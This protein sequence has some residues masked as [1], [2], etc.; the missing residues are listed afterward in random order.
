MTPT[1]ARRARPFPHPRCLAL[2]LLLLLAV[3]A[4]GPASAQDGPVGVLVVSA[5]VEGAEVWVDGEKVG[6]VPYTGY[7]PVG[8]HQVRVVA[9]DHDPFVRRVDLREAL[10]SSL[11]AKLEAGDGTV[12]FKVQPPASVV[13]IDGN[14]VGPAP[15]RIQDLAPGHHSYLVTA[16]GHES[17]AAEFDFAKGQNLFF[18]LELLSSAGLFE[19]D[20]TPP[21]AT[22]WLDGDQVGDTP[23]S[24]S[25][26][27]L[28]QHQVRVALDGYADV[29]RPV[30]TTDGRKGALD[31][32]LTDHGSRLTVKTGVDAASVLVNGSLAGQGARVVLPEVDRGT[33]QVAVSAPGLEP[34]E[35]SVRMPARGR[36]TVKADMLAAADGRSELVQLPPLYGRWTF[37]AASAAVAGGGV[38]GAVILAKA[39]EPPAPPQG[40]VLVVLP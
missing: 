14:P 2:T 28:G 35:L 22:V 38:A 29:F 34:A 26:V 37:W 30:D 19:V 23:L 7:L 32:T 18:E 25:G 3:L 20:T 10:T 40:D 5:S 12:E 24:I 16:D 4:A 31:L 36:V 27:A 13:H 1:A 9:D 15:I 11:D 6:V 39:L 21:G 33:L 8:R 17:A